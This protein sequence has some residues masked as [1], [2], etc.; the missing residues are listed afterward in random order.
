MRTCP[1]LA[2]E[3]AAPHT[4]ASVSLQLQNLDSYIYRGLRGSVQIN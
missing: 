3:A 2:L 4:S 1:L